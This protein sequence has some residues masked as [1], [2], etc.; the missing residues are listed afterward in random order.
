[1][2]DNT[3]VA[4]TG[5]A[6]HAPRAR[7]LRGIERLAALGARPEDTDEERL[8]KATL[9]L[10]ATLMASM[11]VVWV[12]TYWSLG[13]W[14]SGAIPFFYQL[15]TAAG[16]VALGRTK[17]F[18]P[19]RQMQLV[20]ILALPLLLQ[21]SVGGFRTSG[22][23][24]L[25]A[26]MAPLGALLF[27]GVRRATTWFVAFVGATVALGILDP[28]LHGEGHVPN[29]V[30]ITFFVLNVVGVSTTVFLIVRY[31]IRERERILAALRAERERSEQLLLNVLPATIAER[32]KQQPGVIADAF[33]A[34]TVVFADI[35]GF[36]EFAGEAAPEHVVTVLN[37][38]FSRF[39][40][41]AERHG[42]EKIKTIGDG[43]MAVAG[44]PDPRPDHDAAAVEMA[45]DLCAEVERFR[46]ERGIDLAIRVGLHTGPVI[47]GVIGSRKFSYDVWGDTVNLASRMESHGVAGRVQVT[48]TVE[49]R[50]RDRYDFEARGPVDIKGKGLTTTYLV[51]GRR[52]APDGTR[53]ANATS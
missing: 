34:V 30:V 37:A 45:L 47:A 1:M 52:D 3:T 4:M 10:A 40:E 14:R 21:A 28:S 36:T 22:A 13:L 5:P 2:A 50:L 25:W 26:F 31:F 33:A 12:A 48:S 27:E 39:D 7:L 29:A 32:L 8:N 18:R 35:V 38:L 43:Y 46:D 44:L 19:F 15:A 20:M 17:Q 42:I 41:I 49:H 23:V 24:A 11:A 16:L 9:T 51:R 6:T 53:D